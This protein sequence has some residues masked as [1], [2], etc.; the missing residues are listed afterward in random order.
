LKNG[1]GAAS[2]PSRCI[3]RTVLG[4]G[5]LS[6]LTD[7]K[8]GVNGRPEVLPGVPFKTPDLDLNSWLRLVNEIKKE[9]NDDKENYN[10]SSVIAGSDITCGRAKD[11]YSV[12][13]AYASADL[14]SGRRC[15]S[16]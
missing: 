5:V 1:N 14:L 10:N 2:K 11:I 12:F 3:G 13:V 4:T 15:Y 8:P 9:V 6:D 7:L 16:N